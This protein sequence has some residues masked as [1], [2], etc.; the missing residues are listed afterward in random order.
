MSPPDPPG[1]ETPR[2][3]KPRSKDRLEGFQ[4]TSVTNQRQT[5]VA[6]V[7]DHLETKIEVVCR[8][9]RQQEFPRQS[10]REE[11]VHYEALLKANGRPFRKHHFIE[12]LPAA[13]EA[14]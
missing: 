12:R 10:I 4:V 11:F 14:P 3:A 13:R 2:A 9:L 8:L 1:K 6:D 5:Q 7:T